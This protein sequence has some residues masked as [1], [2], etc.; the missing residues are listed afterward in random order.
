M[1]QPHKS[2]IGWDIYKPAHPNSTELRL[3]V[4][5]LVLIEPILKLTQFAHKHISGCCL[6]I[7][8]AWA[9]LAKGPG[10]TWA[11]AFWPVWFPHYTCL[12]KLKHHIYYVIILKVYYATIVDVIYIPC[13]AHSSNLYSI[14]YYGHYARLENSWLGLNWSNEKKNLT[15]IESP[16]FFRNKF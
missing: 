7:W 4:G 1:D 8:S 3:E 14:L 9:Q 12:Y 10:S 13:K 16:P 5:S 11:Y 15:K 6:F 2:F